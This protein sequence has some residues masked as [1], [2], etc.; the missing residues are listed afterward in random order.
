VGDQ[1]STLAM[2][3]NGRRSGLA[4]EFCTSFPTASRADATTSSDGL[5]FGD[6]AIAIAAVGD[7][8]DAASACPRGGLGGSHA[9]RR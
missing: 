7:R 4:S 3:I 2:P 1:H 6:V 5:A 8:F 9:R